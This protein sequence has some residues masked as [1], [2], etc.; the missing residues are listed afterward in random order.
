MKNISLISIVFFSIFVFSSCKKNSLPINPNLAGDW[1]W[2]Y[3]VGGIAGGK[4]VPENGRKRVM[5]FYADSLFSVTE[6]G[7]PS[8]GGTFLLITD[9]TFGKIIRFEPDSFDSYE[10]IYNIKNNE[11]TLFDY[12]ISD[13]Y[14]SYY[15]R[16]K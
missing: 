12:N 10:E 4:I 15:K 16:I 13:G 6:N 3:S 8:F 2:E 5:S 7:N 14:M 9:T 11:L 1:Q